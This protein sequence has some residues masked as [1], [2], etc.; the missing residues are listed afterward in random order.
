[1][2]ENFQAKYGFEG[3]EEGNKFLPRN[4]FRFEVEFE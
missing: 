4:L 3:F 1:V 2:L